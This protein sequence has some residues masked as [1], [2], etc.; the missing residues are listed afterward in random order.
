MDYQKEPGRPEG[1]R[2]HLNENTAGCSPA[3][4]DALRALTPAQV[5]F[6]PDSGPATRACASLMGVDP[7]WVVLTN[8][9]DEGIWATAAACLRQ[10][11]ATGE[12]IIPT[13][14]FD[15]YAA[16]TTAAGGKVVTVAPGP[17]LAFPGAEVLAAISPATRVVFVCSPNNPSGLTVSFDAVSAVARAVPPGALVFLDEAYVDFA[18]TSFLGQ[19]A[20]HPTVVIGRT[21]AKAYGLAALRIGCVL[22]RPDTLAVIRRVIAPYNLNICA[23]E[24]LR[25]AAADTAFHARYCAEVEESRRLLYRFAERHAFEYWPSQANFVLIRV[26]ASAEGLVEALAARAI[27]IRDRGAEP[28]CEGCVRVTAGVVEHARV[29][30][31]AMEEILCERA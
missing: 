9:L 19:L 20:D 3:V 29:C 6:Y 17:H 16:C 13:P 27:F 18:E 14:A 7:S 10:G 4:I 28:G 2:L 23:I 5:A 15:M 24:A 26:G 11:E 30:I 1:L 12:A 31:A 22:A 8:G 25:A 21:F